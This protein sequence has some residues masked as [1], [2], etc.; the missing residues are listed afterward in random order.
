MVIQMTVLVD[1]VVLV[2]LL[3]VKGGEVVVI[4]V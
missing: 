2:L 4:H 3:L 1:L